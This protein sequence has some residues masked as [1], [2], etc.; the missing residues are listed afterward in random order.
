MADSLVSAAVP[1]SFALVLRSSGSIWRPRLQIQGGEIRLFL[2]VWRAERENW[3]QTEALI[4]PPASRGTEIRRKEE[5]KMRPAHPA[6]TWDL[7]VTFQ[8]R[9]SP[10]WRRLLRGCT[11]RV[12]V[13][14]RPDP[15]VVAALQQSSSTLVLPEPD[16]SSSP[17]FLH[18]SELLVFSLRVNFSPAKVF[19]FFLLRTDA[20]LHQDVLLPPR[21]TTLGS[22]T[23]SIRAAASD[24]ERLGNRMLPWLPLCSKKHEKEAVIQSKGGV[25]S[26]SAPPVCSKSK[27]GGAEAGQASERLTVFAAALSLSLHQR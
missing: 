7:N 1:Q 11:I 2:Q 14:L 16:P 19:F 27:G 24:V 15:Q 21:N 8:V 13:V 25:G 18:P 9:S 17:T 6:S 3:Q 4:R 5:K 20:L 10:L 23:C 22:P 12:W 26:S